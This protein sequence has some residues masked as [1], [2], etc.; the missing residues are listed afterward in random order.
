MTGQRAFPGESTAAAVNSILHEDPRPLRELIPD[1]PAS[2]ERTLFR[3]LSKNPDERWQTTNDL[4][5]E[6]RSIASAS[7]DL[8]VPQP[9]RVPLR[10]ER[11]LWVAGLV[12]LSVAVF[13]GAARGVPQ[14]AVVE[15]RPPRFIVP[16]KE[17]TSMPVT[18]S[19]LPYRR[20]GTALSTS[21]SGATGPGNCGF[22]GSLRI[23]SSPN[24]CR[25]QTAQTAR[26]GRRIASG[27][28][29]SPVTA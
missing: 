18:M 22:A 1:L 2:I 3:C 12:A 28:V 27:W 8:A 11:V 14:G 5:F 29:S 16:A 4:L 24:P 21:P 17:P 23:R 19:R 25:V 7:A 10:V 9:R 13:L 20:M 6:L 26:S 15:K